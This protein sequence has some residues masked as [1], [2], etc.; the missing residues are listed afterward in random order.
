MRE[1]VITLIG[2]FAVFITTVQFV[3]QV[4]RAYKLKNLN[5]LSLSTFSLISVTATTWI[6][7]GVLQSDLVVILANA[8][9][10][11]STA[12][13]VARMVYLKRQ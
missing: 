3:P 10:L 4:V 2:I 11:V 6:I 9:V 1:T 7:Y 5:G 13:I 8:F 12:L